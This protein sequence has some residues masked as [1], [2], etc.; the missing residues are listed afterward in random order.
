MNLDNLE[1]FRQI[2]P[3]DMLSHIDALPM[4]LEDAWAHAHTL[5]LPANLADVRQV[6]ICGMGGSAISGDLV[7]ALVEGTCP[8]P[9]TVNR[10]YML[11]AWLQGPDTLIVPISFSG[12]TEETLF[13][14]RQAFERGAKVLAITTGGALGALVSESSGSAWTFDYTSQPR[15]ALGWLYGM[16]LGLFS[17]LG[18][19]ENLDGDV[20]EAVA[21][22]REGRAA[23]GADVLAAHNPAKR[24]A[25][26][27]VGRIPIFWGAGLLAPVARRWKTQ[28]N[29][30]AKTA[31]YYEELPELNHNAVVGLDFPE[32]LMTK[33][34]VIELISK[35]YD[36][37]RVGVRHKAS[38]KLL[39][40]AGIMADKVSEKG[41]SRLA[42]QMSMIQF[43]DYMSYYVAMANRVDPTPVD[44]IRQLKEQLAQAG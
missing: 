2:D 35:K 31:A 36:H 42:Q 10:G 44:N 5:D 25:G 39:L 19:A 24:T 32:A 41:E 9:V 34:C 27:T 8:L 4:Q 15:A 20:Q 22:L 16:L 3:G 14:T 21:V 18:L 13:T 23:L 11:P 38:Y 30:N 43:G 26:Q 1:S 12:G 33:I 37:P 17:R 7:A 6:V 40:Q 29:E 28:F